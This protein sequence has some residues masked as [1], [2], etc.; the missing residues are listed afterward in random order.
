[1]PTGNYGCLVNLHTFHSDI[2]AVFIMIRFIS[3][4]V[5]VVVVVVVDVVVLVDFSCGYSRSSWSSC[6]HAPVLKFSCG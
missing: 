3:R 4:I 6:C 5:V 1:M 2:L